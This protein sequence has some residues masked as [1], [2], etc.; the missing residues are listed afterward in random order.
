MTFYLKIMF[1]LYSVLVSIENSVDQNEMALIRAIS[2]WSTLL[3]KP[4]ISVSR[5]Q[6]VKVV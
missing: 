1:V 4:Q 5:A 2:S 3:N 6:R